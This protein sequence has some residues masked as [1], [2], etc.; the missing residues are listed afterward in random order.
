[1]RRK[2]DLRIHFFNEFSISST[3]YE[4]KPS[5]DNSTQL[6]LL[7][8]YLVASQGRKV[9]KEILMAMLWPEVHDKEPIGALRNLVYRARKELER[10]YPGQ[11]IDYIQFT[12]DA[13]CWNPSLYC[14]IDTTYFE[15]YYS[16]AVQESNPDKQYALYCK[17]HRLYTGR[18]LTNHTGIEW[19]ASRATFYENIHKLCTLKMCEY[20]YEHQNYDE[21]IPLCD[22]S[23]IFYPDEGRFYRYKLETYLTTGAVQAALECYHSTINTFTSRYGIDLCSSLRDIYQEILS[24]LPRVSQ[25]L[26]E[27]ESNLGEPDQQV[28]TFYCNYDIFK[29]IY[30]L[31]SRSYRRSTDSHYLLLLTLSSAGSSDLDPEKIK[32]IQDLLYQILSHQLRKN[33]IFTRTSLTQYAAILTVPNDH[34]C[35]TAAA[36]IIKAFENQADDEAVQIQTEIRQIQ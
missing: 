20:M 5:A 34:G 8:S 35:Q 23:I 22:H 26:A 14:K 12:Q 36:R 6:T 3:N 9:P 16:M 19:I 24:R 21:L 11:D 31:N 30:Q 27:L 15:N 28:S 33:D 18:F 4:Y 10:L 7:L 17:M 25:S 32:P 2:F 13:Y 1:M 29:N